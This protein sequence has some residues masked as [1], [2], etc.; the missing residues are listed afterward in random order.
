M[1]REVGIGV[2]GMGWMGRVHSA[3]YRRLPEH[4]PDLGIRPRLLV[5]ADV[6]EHRAPTP[7]ASAS[8]APRTTGA[9]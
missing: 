5:A 8:S 4:F 3:A 2:I 9:R 1:D 6:S 7:S